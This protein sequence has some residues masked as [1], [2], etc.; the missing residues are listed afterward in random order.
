MPTNLGIKQYKTHYGTDANNTHYLF[1]ACCS[2]LW[3]SVKDH[4]KVQ[5][6]NNYK[7]M[8][9]CN[10]LCAW[11][12]TGRNDD[13]YKKPQPLY[14]VNGLMS[15]TG[16]SKIQKTAVHSTTRCTY[17]ILNCVIQYPSKNHRSIDKLIWDYQHKFWYNR[18]ITN[19]TFIRHCRKMGEQWDSIATICAKA[20]QEW[21]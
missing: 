18:L 10:V 5:I 16:C 3:L 11:R 4:T 20:Q 9:L 2:L 13:N 7:A 6:D 12:P 21:H 1:T 19:S 15:K 17:P 8:G 14:P